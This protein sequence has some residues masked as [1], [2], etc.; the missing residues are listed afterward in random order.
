[1]EHFEVICFIDYPRPIFTGYKHKRVIHF[2]TTH[3]EENCHLQ[4]IPN[5]GRI[6][7]VLY[8]SHAVIAEYTGNANLCDYIPHACLGLILPL[9]S[10]EG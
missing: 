7:E 8:K 4:A 3:N 10:S 1:M 2:D 9:R 5:Q 6:I